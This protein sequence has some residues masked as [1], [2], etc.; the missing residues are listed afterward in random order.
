MPYMGCIS[1]IICTH[2]TRMYNGSKCPACGNQKAR[3]FRETA[4]AERQRWEDKKYFGDP[5]KE[6]TT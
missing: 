1:F 5:E 3:S 2:C 6:R 4:P